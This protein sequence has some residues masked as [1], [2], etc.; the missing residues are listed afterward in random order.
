LGRAFRKIIDRYKVLVGK[1]EWERRLGRHRYRWDDNIK[2]DL[3]KI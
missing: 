1:R 3:R 2:M